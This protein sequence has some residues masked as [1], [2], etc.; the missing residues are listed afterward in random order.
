MVTHILQQTQRWWRSLHF[1]S[2][3]MKLCQDTSR[4]MKVL[5]VQMSVLNHSCVE[6]LILEN[7][8]FFPKCD[9]LSIETQTT[10]KGTREYGTQYQ[11]ATIRNKFTQTVNIITYNTISIQTMWYPCTCL[12]SRKKDNISKSGI[13][14]TEWKTMTLFVIEIGIWNLRNPKIQ[15]ARYI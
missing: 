1:Y 3:Q 13:K 2:F 10:K 4:L 15:K 11:D 7:N 12:E 5:L 9:T 14:R 8:G 6:T